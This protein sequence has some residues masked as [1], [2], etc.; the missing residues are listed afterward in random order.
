[1]TAPNKIWAL[2]A[3]L[4]REDAVDAGSPPSL[5]A[6]RTQDAFA[7]Q[8][9]ET[10][11]HWM[12]FAV[13]AYRHIG[14]DTSAEILAQALDLPEVQALVAALREIRDN[15]CMDPEGN[16]AIAS[17]VLADLGVR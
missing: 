15:P 10:R 13:C 14:P 6:S 1:M 11:N 12:K 16:S 17:A 3:A 2:A 7:D 4:W 9:L 8:S 5:V